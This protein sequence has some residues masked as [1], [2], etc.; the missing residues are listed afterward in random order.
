VRD[1]GC[2]DIKRNMFVEMFSGQSHIAQRTGDTSAGMIGNNDQT[3]LATGVI[4]FKRPG[5]ILA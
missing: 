1:G 4:D 3:R 5:F 2:T